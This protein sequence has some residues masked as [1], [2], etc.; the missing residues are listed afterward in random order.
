[1][2]YYQP[3]ENLTAAWRDDGGAEFWLTYQGREWYREVGPQEPVTVIE[4]AALVGRTRSTIYNWI[5]TKGLQS[6]LA[7]WEGD[8]SD[9][10]KVIYLPELRRFLAQH[11]YGR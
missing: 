3:E 6:S 4:A 11:G 7:P 10:V 2:A 1:M 5:K 8:R 9:E